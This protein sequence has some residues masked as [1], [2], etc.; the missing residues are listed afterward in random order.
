MI[1]IVFII[2]AGALIYVVPTLLQPSNTN[3]E[4]TNYI[5]SCL[6]LTAQDALI[7]IGQQGG[8]LNLPEDHHE[9]N[10]PYLYDKENKARTKEQVAEDLA[11][12]INTN[13]QTCAD[14]KPLHKQGYKT[15]DQQTPVTTILFGRKTVEFILNW[16]FKFQ[17]GEQ[18]LF[19]SEFQTSEEVALGRI[20]EVANQIVQDQVDNPG[21][22]S[23]DN[24]YDDNLDITF[25]AVNNDL[26]TSIKDL[27]Y[28]I[29]NKPFEFVFAQKYRQI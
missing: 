2:L 9:L 6:H 20:I 19:F 22:V 29:D 1:A 26:I 12:Y 25:T 24:Y 4:V 5:T 7:A 13:I 23:I 27:N 8:Y 14:F 10:L 18:Q 28:I 17:K 15:I 3:V 11:Q 21:Q 16:E